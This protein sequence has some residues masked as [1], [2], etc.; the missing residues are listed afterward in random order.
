MTGGLTNYQKALSRAL[1][2]LGQENHY[3]KEQ[4]A[5][6]A[7]IALET[8]KLTGASPNLG[9]DEEKLIREL[10]SMVSWT[11]G[12]EFIMDSKESHVEWLPSRKSDIEWRFWDRYKRYLLEKRKPLS[13]TAVEAIDNITEKVLSRLEDP[14]RAGPW[15][16]RGMIVGQ[17]QS[18]KTGNFIGLINKA[19][20]AGYGIIVVLAGMHEN[21]R[22][23]TQMRIEEGL[24]GYSSAEAT[25]SS[26]LNQPY[27]VGTLVTPYKTPTIALTGYKRDFSRSAAAGLNVSPF[28]KDPI[29]VVVKKNK[30]ILSNLLIWLAGYALSDPNDPRKKHPLPDASL[31]VIDDE[32][33]HSSIN[34]KEI[35]KDP[36]TGEILDD[37]DVNAINGKI[38]QLLSLFTKSAYVGYTA[39]PFAN[40]FVH[41]EDYSE[42]GEVG[43]PPTEILIPYGEGLFPRSFIFSLPEPSNYVGPT[44]IFGGSDDGADRSPLPLIREAADSEPAIPRKHKS[45]FVPS[46]IPPS[47]KRAIRS[48]ILVCA[49]RMHRGD[50]AEHNS[51]LIHVTRF[52]AV[53][54][55]LRE[56]VETEMKDLVQRIR[57]GDGAA[58]DQISLELRQLW[59]EDFEPA[60]RS[61][62]VS[63]PDPMIVEAKWPD[64]EPFISAAAQKIVVKRISG[65]SEDVLDYQRSPDGANV[66]AI[67]G[68]KLSRG[69]TL[70]GLSVSYFLRPSRMYDTLMQMGRWFGYRPGYLDLC[71]LYTTP[72]LVGWYRHIALASAELRSEFET[73][74]E[75]DLTPMDYGL[76]VRSHP[77]GLLITSLVKMRE[78]VTLT[79]SYDGRICE[80]TIF[81]SASSFAEENLAATNRFLARVP[82]I[83]RP[84]DTD[85]WVWS[86]IPASA[87]LEFLKEY[88]THP[89]AP[90]VSS[91]LLA[92][93]ISKCVSDNE[94]LTSWTVV[95]LSS[96]ASDADPTDRF[97]Y[98]VRLVLRKNETESEIGKYT[99][100]RLLSPR[101]EQYGLTKD[102]LIAAMEETKQIW[103]QRPADKRKGEVPKVPSG[104]SLRKQRPMEQGLLLLYPLNPA[105]AKLPHDTPIVGLGISFSG[106]RFNP[107]NA[108]EYEANLVYIGRDLDDE[109]Y[110]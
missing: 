94:H 75:A 103:A 40:I 17:V 38:R 50:K 76:R 65:G 8:V 10:E 97:V 15:D 69:L 1:Q 110:D 57:Y 12:Q 79:A 5:Q 35:P 71:R 80:T 13:R 23:Q 64:I 84:T 78:S 104:P 89:H 27:G 70:E 52:I 96:A 86:G 68:D 7:R 18:G 102:N 11:V 34:T 20:D 81:R 43:K 56:L 108:V 41:P 42:A 26:E 14:H 2:M 29:I 32:A 99:I 62:S 30:T 66:I 101:D 22:S 36:D 74:A 9:I 107:T 73:M 109:D 91:A 58:L 21:L 3:A 46:T 49:A 98:P 48:F 16:R 19:A 55:K 60:T 95:L 28:V 100:K 44:R 106:D 47:L 105:F 63:V 4:I 83:S 39:T 67:G 85:D 24:L 51:M 61:V 82:K 53:Q 31:L 33:D 92:H 59:Q 87:I 45:D 25:T 93:Y 6:I 54:R 88:K 90:E 77:S 37:Y 72:E